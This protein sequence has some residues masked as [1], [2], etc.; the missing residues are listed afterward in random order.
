MAIIAQNISIMNKIEKLLQ[1][2]SQNTEQSILQGQWEFDKKNIPNALKAIAVIFPHYSLHDESHSVSIL[3]NIVKMLSEEVVAKLSCTD[4]WLLLEAAYCHDLGMVVTAARL[5][6]VLRNGEFLKHFM[7]IAAD[8]NHQLYEYTKCFNEKGG[9]LYFNDTE[10][11]VDKFDCSRYLLADFFRSK[12]AENAQKTIAH[13]FEEA[14]IESPRSIIPPRL[15]GMLS[16]ICRAHT[17][18][19][20]N[21][22]ALPQNEDGIGLDEC[23][24]RFVACMLRLGDLLD[25]DNN[26]FSEILMRTIKSMPYESLNHLEKHK[27]ITHLSINS[28]CIEIE[29]ICH[30]PK[31]AQVTQDWFDWINDEFKT[32]TLKWN[33]IIPDGLDCYLPTLNY[34]GTKI[35]GYETVNGKKKPR[36]TID[37]PKAL[38]LLQGKNFYK[39]PLDCIR[40][41]IQ[42]GVDSTL[43]R[44]FNESNKQGKT[45]NS[46]D[47]AFIAFAAQYSITVTIREDKGTY[48]VEISDHGMGMKRDQLTYL[49]NTGSSSKNIEKKLMIEKMPDWMRPSGVFGIGFQSIFLVTDKVEIQTKFCLNDEKMA[50]EMYSPNSP[51]KGDVYLKKVEGTFDV[52]MTVKFDIKNSVKM[53]VAQD[54]FNAVPKDLKRTIIESKIREYASKSVVPITIKY[55]ADGLEHE[56]TIQRII[57]HYYDEETGIELYFN[58]KTFD[59][60]HLSGASYFYRNARVAGNTEIMFLSPEVNIHFGSAKDLLTIDRGSFKDG[61]MIAERTI[62]AI[63]NFM[64]SEAYD[65]MLSGLDN[66]I[67]NNA[68][69]RFSFFIDYY[70]KRGDVQNKRLLAKTTDFQFKGFGDEIKLGEILGAENLRFRSSAV[71]VL[72]IA[73]KDSEVEIQANMM[74]FLS[75]NL[76]VNIAKLVFKLA[77]DKH[78]HC[79]CT[80]NIKG[81]IFA[82]AEYFFTNGDA[83]PEI[84][85][86]MQDIKRNVESTTSRSYINF[87]PGYEDIKIPSEVVDPDIA[88]SMMTIPVPSSKVE[89]IISPFININGKLYD[90]RNDELYK[91]VG[92]ITGKDIK[93]VKAAYDRFV[94][95]AVR[96]G[97]KLE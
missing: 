69:F 89:K 93:T 64:K 79:Y 75:P 71:Q 58:P 34:L 66:E 76:I 53:D 91:Y 62:K 59:F 9:K 61:K 41:I 24:P 92:D 13:P 40:E 12:H 20:D 42:N 49:I 8:E 51:M 5:D 17:Q 84:K 63:V 73:R 83:V 10:F 36:F 94:A 82:Q 38:E 6:C 70:N 35:E 16:N 96:A 74:P 54:P 2:K 23:H 21:V 15:F 95:D 4:L 97:V 81:N 67:R 33:S 87:L 65:S 85:L 77:S 7:N 3:N 19:F 28:K 43:L 78:K 37:T 55:C 46:F 1:D 50:I 56:E 29:A 25:I 11:Q 90:C 48:R 80:E 68:G 88:V 18:N 32:Q 27:A 57:P 39:D 26:R 45:F 30:S 52:G 44:I 31:V 47:E 14:G 72:H 86:T 60:N 22:M